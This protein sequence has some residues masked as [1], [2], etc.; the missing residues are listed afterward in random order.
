MKNINYK[1]L[2]LSERK[3]NDKLHYNLNESEKANKKLRKKFIDTIFP[4]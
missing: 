2:Y 4:E 3:L 1:T